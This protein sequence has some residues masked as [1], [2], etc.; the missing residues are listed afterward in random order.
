MKF[1]ISAVLLL[2]LTFSIIWADCEGL[3]GD[4][5]RDTRV[6][7]SDVVYIINY[8]FSGGNPPGPVLACGDTNGD[9]HVNVSDAV[10]LIQYIFSGGNPPGDCSP[11]SWDGQGGD[12]C[13][14]F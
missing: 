9:A 2:L 5:N 13:P 12:C 4:A 11:G 1:F 7:D 14:F 10:F 8:V 6:A 3:C